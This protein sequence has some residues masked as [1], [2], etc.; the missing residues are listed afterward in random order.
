ARFASLRQGGGTAFRTEEEGRS[1]FHDQRFTCV[2]REHKRGD[3]VDEMLPPP[4]PPARG[5]PGPANSPEH[6]PAENAGP[7]VQKAASA[8]APVDAHSAVI[9]AEQV[10]L[11]RS[12][13][14]GP[15]MKR[16]AAYAERVVDVLVRAGAESVE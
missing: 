13:G 1:S 16:G 5:R 3:V 14:Q 12:C 4:A 2:V 9:P 7:E 15:A 10:L 8:E 6:D 11:K